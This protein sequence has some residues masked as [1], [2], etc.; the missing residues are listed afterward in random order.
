[1]HLVPTLSLNSVPAFLL[2]SKLN[3]GYPFCH[4]LL[5][6]FGKATCVSVILWPI[7]ILASLP[8][9]SFVVHSLGY[10]FLWTLHESKSANISPSGTSSRKLVKQRNSPPML[11]DAHRT[12][13]V[14]A[15]LKRGMMVFETAVLCKYSATDIRELRLSP[16]PR[17]L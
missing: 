4:Q 1:M 9:F 6:L 16:S 7:D 2:T 10:V 17:H 11:L 3:A 15:G 14:S 8:F 13:Q 5:E 12:S